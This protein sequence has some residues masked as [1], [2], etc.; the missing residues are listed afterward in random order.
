MRSDHDIVDPRTIV[1]RKA[2]PPPDPARGISDPSEFI[3]SWLV[4]LNE[5]PEI[6]PLIEA[7]RPCRWGSLRFS[8]FLGGVDIGPIVFLRSGAPSFRRGGRVIY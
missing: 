7:T 6:N 4:R 2:A 8:T 3:Q 1:S 5:H